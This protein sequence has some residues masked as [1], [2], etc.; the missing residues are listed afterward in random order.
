MNNANNTQG[1][2][3]IEEVLNFTD[4]RVFGVLFYLAQIGYVFVRRN[5]GVRLL[6]LEMVLIS[7]TALLLLS[8]LANWL[9]NLPFVGAKLD[10]T[11]FKLFGYIYLFRAIYHM[12]KAYLKSRK[13]PFLYSRHIGDSYISGWILQLNAPFFKQNILR[14]NAFAEPLAMFVIAQIISKTLSPNLGI[15]LIII[16]IAMCAVGVFIIN[17][18]DEHRYNLNDSMVLGEMTQQ[19]MEGMKPT[20]SKG[21]TSRATSI[22]RPSP[23]QKS[24]NKNDNR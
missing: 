16:S 13:I 2:K 6:K 3:H 22:T 23:A 1:K 24:H 5:F 11:S 10:Y 21:N 20:A 19:N 7:W 9:T 15:L 18:H 17:N 12:V 4:N 14:I 8:E